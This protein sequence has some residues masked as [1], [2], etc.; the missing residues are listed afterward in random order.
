MSKSHLNLIFH[1]SIYESTLST[2]HQV[3][4]MY[5]Y[6]YLRVNGI[7]ILFGYKISSVAK[8]LIK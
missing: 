1:N 3:L 2:D 5:M 7:F 8:I 6:I 4:N